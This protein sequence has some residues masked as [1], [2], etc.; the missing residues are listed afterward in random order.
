MV[1][2][3]Y[4]TL[5]GIKGVYSVWELYNNATSESI[6]SFSYL[7]SSLW[8]AVMKDKFGEIDNLLG[9]SSIIGDSLDAG[10]KD[11]KRRLGMGRGRNI[12]LSDL[13]GFDLSSGVVVKGIDDLS[14]DLFSG[15]C[16]EG[17]VGDE[18]FDEVGCIDWFTSFSGGVT[19]VKA[20]V[21]RCHVRLKSVSSWD[22]VFIT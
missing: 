19:C 5:C 12:S 21:V 11:G 18:L 14:C 16:F 2:S 17:I 9:V 6:C 10:L 8:I 3:M 1:F 20:F 15:V 22:W 4:Q 13:L 7:S